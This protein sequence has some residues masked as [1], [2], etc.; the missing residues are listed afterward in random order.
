MKIGEVSMMSIM[1]LAR[2]CI[3]W[4]LWMPTISLAASI[5]LILCTVSGVVFGMASTRLT[6]LIGLVSVTGCC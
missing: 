2:F 1:A 5:L 4:V 3:V 6:A